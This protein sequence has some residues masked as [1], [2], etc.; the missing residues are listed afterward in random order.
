M[1]VRLVQLKRLLDELT[2][3]PMACVTDFLDLKEFNE[4]TCFQNSSYSYH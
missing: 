1:Q 4:M 2:P 3:L